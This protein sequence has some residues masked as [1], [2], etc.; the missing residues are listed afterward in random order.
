MKIKGP[1]VVLNSCNY[2]AQAFYCGGLKDKYHHD[3]CTT[4]LLPISCGVL[5]VLHVGSWIS[6]IAIGREKCLIYELKLAI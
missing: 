3:H 4:T 2:Q 1:V 6:E 5:D